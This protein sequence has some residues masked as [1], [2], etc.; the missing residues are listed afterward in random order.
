MENKTFNFKSK[1]FT[2]S[3]LTPSP[4]ARRLGINNVPTADIIAALQRLVTNVLDPLRE[5]W[6]VYQGDGESD[7]F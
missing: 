4:T 2:L 6:D 5:E 3:E 7:T 1:Y